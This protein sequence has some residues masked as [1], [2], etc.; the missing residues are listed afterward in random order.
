MEDGARVASKEDGHKGTIRY[1]GQLSGSSRGSSGVTWVGV[2]WDDPSRGTGDGSFEGI[3][4]F[5]T[6]SGLPKSGSFAKPKVLLL[7]AGLE[8]VFR[9]THS[10]DADALGIYVRRRSFKEISQ[11][12]MPSSRISS[13]LGV[14]QVF[15]ACPMLASLDLSDNLLSGWKDVF[16]IL[17]TVATLKFLDVS[18]NALRGERRG[19][20]KAGETFVLHVLNLGLGSRPLIGLET[21]KTGMSSDGLSRGILDLCC[22]A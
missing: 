17:R 12:L 14:E 4:Y 6:A 7:G 11:C 10:E 13:A 9:E 3:R 20:R 16:L 19:M 22:Q 15:A 8:S 18:N 21:P 5:T 2:E 1:V